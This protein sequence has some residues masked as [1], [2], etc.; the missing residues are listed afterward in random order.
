MGI[1]NVGLR[2]IYGKIAISKHFGYIKY[3][4]LRKQGN[5]REGQIA[6]NAFHRR[7]CWVRVS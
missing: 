6:V 5:E 1:L 4:E 2:N 3:A 7:C